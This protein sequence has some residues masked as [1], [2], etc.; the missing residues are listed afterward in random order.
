MSLAIVVQSQTSSDTRQTVTNAWTDIGLTS[1][2]LNEDSIISLFSSTSNDFKLEAGVYR[3][4]SLTTATGL[5]SSSNINYFATRLFNVTSGSAAGSSA[6]PNSLTGVVTTPS[7][8][9]V[10]IQSGGFTLVSAAT[11][12]MQIKCAYGGV[13]PT[14]KSAP[15]IGVADSLGRRVNMTLKIIKKQ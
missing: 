13:N 14:S 15:R 9:A 12:K 4:E 7:G 11:F 2:I 1:L 10:M 3:F 6:N 5:G 8:G